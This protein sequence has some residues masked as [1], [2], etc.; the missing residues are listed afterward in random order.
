M[1]SF[2]L[3]LC[4]TTLAAACMTAVLA[5]PVSAKETEIEIKEADVPG[6]VLVTVKR[7]YPNAKATKFELEEEDGQRLYEVTLHQGGKELE[8]KLTAQGELVEE[9]E[10]I[11][12]KDLPD[13]VRKSLAASR[14]AKAKIGKIERVVRK[15]KKAPP[16]FEIKVTDAGKTV[17]LL[18]DAA[19]KLL[20]HE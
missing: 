10:V 12:E 20:G 3:N 11:T 7:H 19:G 13:P 2:L 15:D 6:P 5:A 8:A 1:R 9:E 18:Y 4:R 16:T 17:E 14:Y